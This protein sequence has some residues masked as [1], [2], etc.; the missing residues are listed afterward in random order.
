[1]ALAQHQLEILDRVV[2]Y[3]D[4]GASLN[5][6]AS[7]QRPEPQGP[8]ATKGKGA[9]PSTPSTSPS[10]G[11]GGSGV[12]IAPTPFLPVGR[13]GGGNAPS[14]PTGY[15]KVARGDAGGRWQGAAD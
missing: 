11:K 8:G 7:R 4:D 13:R 12:P 9:V 1:M 2:L 15:G 10:I 14:L 5:V 3:G 6:T